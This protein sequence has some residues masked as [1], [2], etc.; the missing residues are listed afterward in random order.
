M[1]REPGPTDCCTYGCN[2]GRNCLVRMSLHIENGGARI[3][4]DMPKPTDGSDWV[5]FDKTSVVIFWAGAAVMVVALV[6]LFASL[7]F[8]LFN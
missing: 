7:K 2:Q 3:N 4:T 6:S 8:F 5:F 1:N